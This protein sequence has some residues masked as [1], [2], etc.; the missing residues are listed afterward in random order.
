MIY[1]SS[2]TL[3]RLT[4]SRCRFVRGRIE[5]L[6]N[7]LEI[8]VARMK[9]QWSYR[10]HVASPSTSRRC[11]VDSHDWRMLALSSSLL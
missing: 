6:L 3:N 2:N 11:V 5:L 10:D 8:I 1:P 9:I 7:V 4:E